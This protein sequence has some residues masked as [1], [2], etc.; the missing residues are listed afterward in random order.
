MTAIWKCSVPYRTKPRSI[1]VF[2]KGRKPVPEPEPKP[3]L[4]PFWSLFQP[5][6]TTITIEKSDPSDMQWWLS[7]R[8]WDDLIKEKIAK[9]GFTLWYWFEGDQTRF[10]L[11]R[12]ETHEEIQKEIKNSTYTYTGITE[13]MLPGIPPKDGKVRKPKP[14]SRI[15]VEAG[16]D[17]IKEVWK[18]E[19]GDWV[20]VFGHGEVPS[21]AAPKIPPGDDAPLLEKTASMIRDMHYH[22]W[23]WLPKSRAREFDLTEVEVY[24]LLQ[25]AVNDAVPPAA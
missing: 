9:R 4:N 19:C 18:I 2:G 13:I 3:T 1:I 11:C 24:D 20:A 15:H 5:A 6:G 8:M 10:D 21:W 7:E 17:A 23:L 16:E 12:V 25:T 14:G 22:L